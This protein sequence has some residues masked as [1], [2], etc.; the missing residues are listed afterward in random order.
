MEASLSSLA[1]RFTAYE[2]ASPILEILHVLKTFQ[3]IDHNEIEQ[4]TVY[5]VMML[6]VKM[7]VLVTS[8]P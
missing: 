7:K 3:F 4:S 8:K 5:I 6:H 2:D 1:I